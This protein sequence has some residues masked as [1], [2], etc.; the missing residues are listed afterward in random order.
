MP[1]KQQ[2]IVA[3][4]RIESRILRI[5]GHK[6]MLSSDL[7]ALYGV[8]TRALVQAVKRNRERFPEDFMVQLNTREFADLK[9]QIVISSWGGARRARPYA[10]TEQGVAM[11]S[12]VLR[13]R[14]AV[15]VNIEIM[16]AFV[17][18]RYVLAVHKALAQKLDELEKKYKEHDAQFEAVFDAIR[19]LMTP[20]PVTHPPNRISQRKRNA[21]QKDV[22]AH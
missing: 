15:R 21:I 7:A 19:E 11:L 13:S 5:R 16:R 10:F 9:S 2:A 4:G 12:S 22:N 3:A 6:V 8:E 1:T 18:L 17:R 14:R 20:P